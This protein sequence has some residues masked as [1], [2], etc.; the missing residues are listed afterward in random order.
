[1]H[2]DISPARLYASLL[3]SGE[4]EV[5]CH[6]QAVAAPGE[7]LDRRLLHWLVWQ[8]VDPHTGDS[9]LAGSLTLSDAQSRSGRVSIAALLPATWSGGRLEVDV[10]GEDG[11]RTAQVAW[12]VRLFEQTGAFLPP[13]AGFTLVLVGHRTGEVHRLAQIASQ[14]FAWDMLALAGDWRLLSAP[15]SEATR[16]EDF[17]GFGQ[18]VHATAPG[19]VVTAL[20]GQPDQPNVGALPD[21]A[22][23]K[24]DLRLALGNAVIIEH[25]DGV[26]CCMAHLKRGSVRVAAGEQVAAGQVVG[27]LGNSG[28]SSGPHLH[29]HFMDGPDFLNASP[30]PV[31]FDIEGERFAPQ[32]GA[33]FSGI[34]HNT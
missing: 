18:P 21:P 10:R 27:A 8:F 31:Q 2:L 1:M 12:D 17:Y 11:I 7:T 5:F 3:P 26:Y 14:G 23:F 32:C 15:Y 29:I 28:F 22:P 4:R 30:L 13:L 16:P 33:I 9:A 25:G 24:A 19:R 34:S 6:V 20:D